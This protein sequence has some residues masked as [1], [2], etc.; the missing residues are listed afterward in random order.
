MAEPGTSYEFAQFELDGARVL[1][2][3]GEFG[4]E[5]ADEFRGQVDGALAT[6]APVVLDLSAV[7]FMDSTALS[8]ILNALKESW[9]RGQ[10][11]LIA[12]PLRQQIASL[13]SI[14]GVSRYV[15]VHESWNAAIEA[16]TV[17]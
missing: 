6:G 10:A 9:A 17:R 2:A 13:F 3:S 1:R 16:L 14:T 12:G 11:L 4:L 8:V 7:D 15:T 5:S